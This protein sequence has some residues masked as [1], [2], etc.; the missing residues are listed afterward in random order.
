MYSIKFGHGILI[1]RPYVKDDVFHKVRQKMENYITNKFKITA[2]KLNYQ[3]VSI[4]WVQTISAYKI[5][6]C[7][8]PSLINYET[9][10]G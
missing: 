9:L 3:N 10:N 2:I 1:T 6:A 4:Q 7:F 8:P 5:E